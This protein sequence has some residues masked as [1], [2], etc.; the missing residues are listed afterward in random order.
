M[1]GL[2]SL[3]RLL[4]PID[5]MAART[6]PF[7]PTRVPLGLGGSVAAE[8]MGGIPVE[9]DPSMAQQMPPPAR[10][11]PGIGAT[12]RGALPGLLRGAAVGLATPS[13][14]VG[15]MDAARAFLGSSADR[16]EQ[17]M[18]NLQLQRQREQD[19]RQQQVD[20]MRQREFEAEMQ[21]QPFK[22]RLLESQVREN[23]AQAARNQAMHDKAMR[24]PAA[25]LQEKIAAIKALYPNITD[26]EMGT[27]IGLW[28][29]QYDPRRSYSVTGAESANAALAMDTQD[30]AAREEYL[31]RA[32]QAKTLGRGP[33]V[34]PFA[35][36]VIGNV[37]VDQDEQ[38]NPRSRVIPGVP[39]P[40][41]R[42]TGG[43]KPRQ[44]TAGQERAAGIDAAVSQALS[45]AE[46]W[47]ASNKRTDLD[48]VDLAIK[49]A[50]TQY[51]NDPRFTQNYA[52]IVSK[53]QKLKIERNR[54]KATGSTTGGP[55][56]GGAGSF[57]NEL[58]SGSPLSSS[59]GSGAQPKA[60]MRFNPSTGRLE[61]I[62]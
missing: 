36:R 9:P 49:N 38:G 31:K 3:L 33:S 12:L 16:D 27:A 57:L 14:G 18:R 11:R 20:Q 44:M 15:A 28:G 4:G 13:T 5:P 51:R 22:Q 52:A 26:R 60:A 10:P 50:R 7:L 23:D 37:M 1:P 61:P 59:S 53:L 34:R 17:M 56:K 29:P 48:P 62:R 19:M 40:G 58:E 54:T 32:E 2:A 46:S 25:D 43:A 8:D 42:A 24:T 35:P 41:V 21:M 6:P 47:I 55:P 45:E 30:P 39:A